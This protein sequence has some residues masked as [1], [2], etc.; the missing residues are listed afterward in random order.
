MLPLSR[1]QYEGVLAA[2]MS[3]TPTTLGTV[4]V[5]S[6]VQPFISVTVTALT[7]AGKPV[8]DRVVSPFAQ[9]KV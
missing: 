7:P 5:V 9:R 6:T 8:A 2:T 3:S 1:P 4:T